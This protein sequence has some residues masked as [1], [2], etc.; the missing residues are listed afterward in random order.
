MGC[1]DGRILNAWFAFAS[2]TSGHKTVH[3]LTA[4]DV[5]E[6]KFVMANVVLP[7]PGYD[8]IYP[9]NQLKDVF[10]RVLENDGLCIDNMR[11]KCKDFSLPGSYR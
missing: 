7:L 2:D 8:V 4:E 5:S 3:I 6:G 9:D 11:H 10:K 1:Y